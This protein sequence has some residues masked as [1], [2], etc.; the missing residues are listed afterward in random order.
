VID[1]C[2][3]LN[4]QK[5]VPVAEKYTNFTTSLS[6]TT[7]SLNL[8]STPDKGF[9]SSFDTVNDRNQFTNINRNSS[10]RYN[11]KPTGV[12][13][14]TQVWIISH[15]PKNDGGSL[16]HA[17]KAIYDHK[18]DNGN[19]DH[20]TDIILTVGW[21]QCTDTLVT[22]QIDQCIRPIAEDIAQLLKNW[23]VAN[24]SNVKGIGNSMGTFMVTEISKAM[25]DKQGIGNMSN[26]YLLDP[27]H[28]WANYDSVLS[29][30]AVDSL[31][32]ELNYSV[33]ERA[34]AT[35][36][37][38]S[39]SNGYKHFSPDSTIIAYTGVSN[40]GSDNAC[41]N[42]WLNT[43]ADYNVNMYAFEI[44]DVTPVTGCHIHGGV[45]KVWSK[46]INDKSMANSP[47]DLN[48]QNLSQFQR[49]TY[50]SENEKG[51]NQT[52]N[53]FDT[54]KTQASIIV[55]G[56]SEDSATANAYTKQENGILN[57]YGNTGQVNQFSNYPH[58]SDTTNNQKTINIQNFE[59]GDKINLEKGNNPID[60]KY[61]D[62]LVVGSSIK[63]TVKTCST[64]ICVTIIPYHDTLI[65][66]TGG[67]GNGGVVP[68]S[69]TK[70][71]YGN[72]QDKINSSIQLRNI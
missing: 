62:Y 30:I 64:G 37:K 24:G 3:D 22:P 36:N 7:Y 32:S 55:P 61:S 35:D 16:A 8:M 18:D 29:G 13:T 31:F 42:S 72:D 10:Y 26:L 14:N 59:A 20:R 25:K 38:Y 50:F 5:R 9:D 4:S 56:N 12:T 23:G 68:D 33:D 48:N 52:T 46:L 66:A 21:K 1:R 70:A 54:P 40:N 71:L 41:G 63:R 28:F 15:G 65:L 39:R 43:T 69:L 45:H 17:A 58:S 2:S 19:Y 44:F 67:S 49:T 6:Q 53:Q 27:P 57:Q 11:Y 47:F 51:Y 60:G 34:G